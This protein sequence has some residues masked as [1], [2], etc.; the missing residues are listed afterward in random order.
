MADRK[1][2]RLSWLERAITDTR[3]FCKAIE[4]DAEIEGASFAFGS[5]DDDFEID[6]NHQAELARRTLASMEEERR[7]IRARNRMREERR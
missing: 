3:R 6:L 7:S 4:V 1:L 2:D 5:L